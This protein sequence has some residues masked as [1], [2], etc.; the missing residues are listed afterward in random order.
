MTELAQPIASTTSRS[1]VERATVVEVRAEVAF[2]GRTGKRIGG[3]RNDQ[4]AFADDVGERVDLQRLVH[5]RTHQRRIDDVL[6]V[7][8]AYGQN[9]R[10]RLGTL[11]AE[12][13][14]EGQ[15]FTAGETHVDEDQRVIAPARFLERVL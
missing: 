10:G 15:C 4:R 5:H 11:F 6:L 3:R 14:Q 9:E 7:W 13:C 8:I 1:V 2:G 12:A